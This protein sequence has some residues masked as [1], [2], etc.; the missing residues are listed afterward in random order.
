MTLEISFKN[1]LKILSSVVEIS[2]SFCCY[3]FG[4]KIGVILAVCELAIL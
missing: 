4:K 3:S 2:D 1:N